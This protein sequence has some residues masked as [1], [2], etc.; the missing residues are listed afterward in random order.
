VRIDNPDAF[1]VV[2]A[3]HSITV[4]CCEGRKQAAGCAGRIG[5]TIDIC[6]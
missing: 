1:H 5:R 2:H 4:M 6:A 3:A